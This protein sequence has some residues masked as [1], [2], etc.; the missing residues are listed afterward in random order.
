[1]QQRVEVH[2]HSGHYIIWQHWLYA[3]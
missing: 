2:L 3:A 1:M